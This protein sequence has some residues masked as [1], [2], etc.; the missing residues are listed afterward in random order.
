RSIAGF[1]VADL[2]P[3]N[4]RPLL[5]RRGGLRRSSARIRKNEQRNARKT[6]TASSA[7]RRSRTISPVTHTEP[8]PRYPVVCTQSDPPT[9][10]RAT[11][12]RNGR[13]HPDLFNRLPGTA[14]WA[15]LMGMELSLDLQQRIVWYIDVLQMRVFKMDKRADCDDRGS[16]VANQVHH[17]AD[18]FPGA[19]YVVYENA[20]DAS[21]IQILPE[22]VFAAFLLG[23]ENL[24]GVQCL[25]DTERD[26]NTSGI[27][28]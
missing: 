22:I 8:P 3:K 28:R 10:L 26:R 14:L 20:I 23:P 6:Q 4:S 19:H 24:I 25:S 17:L 16:G 12:S 1:H 7:H 13:L 18:Y 9:N 27:L 11:R 2:R 21:R 5:S 15:L